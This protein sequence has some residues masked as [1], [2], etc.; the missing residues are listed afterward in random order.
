MFHAKKGMFLVI[1]HK[2]TDK[3]FLNL[4]IFAKHERNT[5]KKEKI[6]L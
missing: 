2:V 5:R 4:L 1:K 3:M 6:W